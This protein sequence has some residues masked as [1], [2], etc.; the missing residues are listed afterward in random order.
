MLTA[1]LVVVGTLVVLVAA[2]QLWR[3]IDTRAAS[4]AW[5]RLIAIRADMPVRFESAMVADLPEPARRYFRFMIT[6]GAAI[7]TVVEIE[8]DGQL[9]LG[10]K[11]APRYQ[12]MQAHQVLVPPHGFVWRLDAGHAF[13][14]VVGSDG[15]EADRSWVRFWLMSLAPVVRAGGNPDHLRAAFG[16]VVA[17]TAFWAPAALLPQ[18]GTRWEAV[19]ANIA[20]ATMP[21]GGMTQ[22][23]DIR[24]DDGGRPRWIMIQRWTDANPDK[25]YRIQPF[26]GHLSDFREVA[27]Y[28]LP[29]RVEG[30][31]FFG[32]DDYFPFYKATVKNIRVHANADAGAPSQGRPRPL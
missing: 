21:H 2:L 11:E 6:P 10:T 29:F 26:G 14:R 25:R 24:V 15:M 7:G 30:G 23:V 19:D 8:M 28:R 5:D 31:N 18:G 4:A 3:W 12:P 17:E 27:G 9:S 20:R 32:T 22:A 1:L 16:R 13:M